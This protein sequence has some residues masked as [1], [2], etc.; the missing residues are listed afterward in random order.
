M[1]SLVAGF[2]EGISNDFVES[3]VKG[4]VICFTNSFVIGFVNDFVPR[5]LCVCVFCPAGVSCPETCAR[6]DTTA[7]ATRSPLPPPGG[8]P[9]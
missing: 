5:R 7:A 3:L 4:F 1:A 8:V 9:V 6:F 2:V